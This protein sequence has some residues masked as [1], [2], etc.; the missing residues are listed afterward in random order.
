MSYINAIRR[1][2][3]FLSS[4]QIGNSESL[5]YQV[6]TKYKSADP[7]LAG[8]LRKSIMSQLRGQTGDLGGACIFA[9]TIVDIT[10]ALFSPIICAILFGDWS[11]DKDKPM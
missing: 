8:R 4:R 9:V 1:A 6:I 7:Y 11:D 10:R 3:S 2:P 5:D